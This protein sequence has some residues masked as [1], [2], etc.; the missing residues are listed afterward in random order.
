MKPLTRFFILL[1]ISSQVTA[2]AFQDEKKSAEAKLKNIDAIEAMAI[3]NQW[4][5]SQKEIKSFVTP[6]E[7]TFKF[8]S[9]KVKKIPLPAEKMV[10]AVAPFINRTHE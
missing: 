5:W 3:A 4:K 8:S 7:V 9:G 10:V 6:R 1:V 2:C